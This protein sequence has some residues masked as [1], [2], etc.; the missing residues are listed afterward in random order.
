MDTLISAVVLCSSIMVR[1]DRIVPVLMN[2]FLA[3][4]VSL[5]VYPLLALSV[6]LQNFTPDVFGELLVLHWAACFVVP[7]T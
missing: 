4:S 3:W 2:T 6:L 5:V 1:L 7:L